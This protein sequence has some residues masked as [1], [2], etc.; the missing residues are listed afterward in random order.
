MNRDE[1]IT[2]IANELFSWHNYDKSFNDGL[3]KAE[4]ILE[5][6]EEKNENQVFTSR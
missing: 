5:M 6:I 2:L 3:K 4:E 1:K